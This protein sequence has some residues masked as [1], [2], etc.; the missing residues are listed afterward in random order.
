MRLEIAERYNKAFAGLK[1]LIISPNGG[2][3][4]LYTIRLRDAEKRDAFIEALQKKGIGTSV[5]FI[6]LHIMPYYRERYN[7]KPEDFPNS[8]QRFRETVSLP[9]W[10][11]MIDEQIDRVIDAVIS[12]IGC[13]NSISSI[14]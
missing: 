6:P 5:H 10:P 4:H 2:A 13:I 1:E 12:S 14:I 7:L 3:R 8:Y 9:I 11:G